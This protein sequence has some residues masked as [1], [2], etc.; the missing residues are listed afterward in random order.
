MKDN[1]NENKSEYSIAR[2]K[3]NN[4]DEEED[5]S[6]YIFKQDQLPQV[7]DNNLMNLGIQEQYQ[8]NKL[9]QIY[10]RS[11]LNKDSTNSMQKFPFIDKS[12]S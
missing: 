2:G 1:M 7:G 10:F 6:N 5:Q 8:Q 4:N 9:N 3:L 12:G 11:K